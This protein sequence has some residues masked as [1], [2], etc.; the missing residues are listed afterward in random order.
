MPADEGEMIMLVKTPQ[1]STPARFPDADPF[2]AGTRSFQMALL[3]RDRFVI[4]NGPLTVDLQ[5]ACARGFEQ[6][7]QWRPS[8]LR[9]DSRVFVRQS[10]TQDSTPH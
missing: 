7:T 5:T 3:S 10:Y 2:A 6:P 4:L 8:L 1:G 9:G